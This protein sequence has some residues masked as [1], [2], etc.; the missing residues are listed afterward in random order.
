L[1]P[2]LTPRF[3]TVRRTDLRAAFIADF[4]LAMILYVTGAGQ[5]LKRKGKSQAFDYFGNGSV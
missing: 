5:R 2:V 3:R 1:S 4:V